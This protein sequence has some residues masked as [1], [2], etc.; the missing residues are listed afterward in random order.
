M[1]DHVWVGKAD[2]EDLRKRGFFISAGWKFNGQGVSPPGGKFHGSCTMT[3]ASDPPS[4]VCGKG[5]WGVQN[6]DAIKALQ[7]FIAPP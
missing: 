1:V 6:D 2:T 7:G 3:E 5:S 4:V